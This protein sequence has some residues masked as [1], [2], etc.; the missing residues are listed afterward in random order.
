MIG[1]VNFLYLRRLELINFRNFNRQ[2]IEPGIFINLLV[3]DNAQGKT[4]L[5]EAIYFA[6]TGRSFRTVKEKEIINRER[7]YACVKCRLETERRNIDLK[8]VLHPGKKSININGV[9]ARGFP[10]GW[11]GVVLFTPDDLRIIK[12]SPQERR[13]FFDLEVGPF[14]PGYSHYLSR[15]NKIITQRNI[16]LKEVRARKAKSELLNAWNDQLCGYGAKILFLRI[17]LL[18]KFY[19]FVKELH[20]QLTGGKEEIN[21]NYLS[22]LNIDG[23]TTEEAIYH[24]LSQALPRIRNE[25]I[26]RAQ[27]L[28]GPH[29]D[30]FSIMINGAD[31]RIYGSRGQVRTIILG[32]KIS[33][34]MLWYQEIS[35]YPVLLMDDVMFELDKER[36]R[37]IL[38]S[39]GGKVQTFITATSEQDLD[40]KTILRKNI[41]RV[42][43]GK[44]ID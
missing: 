30:D 33:L 13:R 18:K 20:R 29:R 10:L 9:S 28:I 21:L 16:L 14:H 24:R 40:Q 31:A 41:Y 35:E 7:D 8:A 11:P 23:A 1:R 27:T 37:L 25:E 4:N 39:M 19:P 2:V 32:F 43:D 17:Y 15:Y 42:A 38:K 6:C 3:G 12:G 36:R 34:V 22:S 5:L 44:I 26:G